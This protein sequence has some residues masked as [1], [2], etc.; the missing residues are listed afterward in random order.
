MKITPGDLDFKHSWKEEDWKI[1]SSL[2]EV[3]ARKRMLELKDLLLDIKE[4][5]DD[6]IFLVFDSSTQSILDMFTA[7]AYWKQRGNTLRRYFVTVQQVKIFA[8]VGS[9]AA[10]GNDLAMMRMGGLLSIKGE[11]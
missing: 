5:W 9:F 11:Q 4:E 7:D 2:K 6:I 1:A 3:D 8:D 10:E